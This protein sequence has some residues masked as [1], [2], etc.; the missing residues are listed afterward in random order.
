M[1]LKTKSTYQLKRFKRIYNDL[2][3]KSNLTHPKPKRFDIFIISK[4]AHI[5]IR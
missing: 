2:I 3:S 4:N 1:F 5:N